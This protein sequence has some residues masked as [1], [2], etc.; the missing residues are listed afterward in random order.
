MNAP[1]ALA[2]T[3]S[4]LEWIDRLPRNE[5]TYFSLTAHLMEDGFGYPEKSLALLQERV[6]DEMAVLHSL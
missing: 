6:T 3:N 5:E 1:E 2:L 4:L